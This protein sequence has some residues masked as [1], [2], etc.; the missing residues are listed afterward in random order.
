MQVL[1]RGYHI[2]AG[3]LGVHVLTTTLERWTPNP[4]VPAITV[5]REPVYQPNPAPAGRDTPQH[6]T[7]ADV[8]A[9]LAPL[10]ATPVTDVNATNANITAALQAYAG[11]QRARKPARPPPH[12]VARPA[13]VLTAAEAGHLHQTNRREL[14]RRIEAQ[15]APALAISA[16]ALAAHH[17]AEAAAESGLPAIAATLSGLASRAPYGTYAADAALSAPVTTAEVEQHIRA[18][19]THAAATADGVAGRHFRDLARRGDDD[20]PPR[21]LVT[22]LTRMFNFVTANA[23]SPDAW[24]TATC[25]LLPKPGQ[26]PAWRSSLQFIVHESNRSLRANV[27][28]VRVV[29][30][31]VACQRS[32]TP[33]GPLR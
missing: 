4:N 9:L 29:W 30:L 5:T 21:P 28:A 16:A 2:P 33:H 17:S 22:A 27:R 20:D 13:K 32:R 1:I 19:R 23:D 14:H 11:P 31:V 12:R 3:D 24:R 7:A 18:M 8:D 26:G 15:P 25:T 10:A 6:T